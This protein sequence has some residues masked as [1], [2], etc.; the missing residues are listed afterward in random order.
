[1]IGPSVWLIDAVEGKGTMTIGPAKS[2]DEPGIYKAASDVLVVGKKLYVGEEDSMDETIEQGY[3]SIWNISDSKSPKLIKRL[4][5]GKE[6]P[7]DFK[8]AHEIYATRDGRY[9]GLGPPCQDR[10]SDGRGDE[11]GLERGCGVAHASR[12]LRAGST[13][14]AAHRQSK[15]A[16]GKSHHCAPISNNW[17]RGRP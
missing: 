17:I 12:Q 7:A 11:G 13:S 4:K 9:V 15:F 14:I 6:L 10:W 1:V 8:L 5:P 2:P 16:L 3:V